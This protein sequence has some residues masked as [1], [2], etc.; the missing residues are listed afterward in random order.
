V[1]GKCRLLPPI[2][3]SVQY[4]AASHLVLGRSV[5]QGATYTYPVPLGTAKIQFVDAS[6]NPAV[7]HP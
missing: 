6:G 7:L 1:V 3:I 4:P 2:S 5:A